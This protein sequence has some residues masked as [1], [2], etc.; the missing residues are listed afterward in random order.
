MKHLKTTLYV[1][2]AS[3]TLILWT[4][5]HA[6][7]QERQTQE[8]PNIIFML[9]DDM[10]YDELSF[11]GKAVLETPNLDRLAKE[12]TFFKNAYVTTSI[13]VVSRVSIMT[14]MYAR[15]HGIYGFEEAMQDTLWQQSYPML[16][17]QNGYKT[18]YIGKFGIADFMW[19]REVLPL[20]DFDAWYGAWIGQGEYHE[21]DENRHPIHLTRKTSQQAVRFI[22]NYRDEPFCLAIGFKTPHLPL[23]PDPVYKNHFTEGIIL[24]EN[25]TGC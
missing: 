21:R 6:S 23:Q 1:G 7:A 22:N 11:L 13:C 12:G 20:Y 25:W 15:R 24:W 19:S 9:A 2:I 18:G 10:R 5:I 17:R 4:P 14:G 8:R 16:L 3:A